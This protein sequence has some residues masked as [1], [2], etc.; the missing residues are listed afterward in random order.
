MGRWFLI[1]D[2]SRG[3]D[4]QDAPKDGERVLA[5]TPAAL[6]T[7]LRL[8]WPVIGIDRFSDDA[9]LNELAVRNFSDV[10]EAVNRL[11]T[12]WKAVRP[13][14]LVD[15][16]PFLATAFM[17]KLAADSYTF[18]LMELM[19]FA[20]IE[21]PQ[22]VRVQSGKSRFGPL[23]G[24]P[25]HTYNT[26]LVPEGGE[27]VVLPL[28]TSGA[29][30]NHVDVTHQ[31]FEPIPH[32]KQMKH[33]GAR[34]LLRA[35]NPNRYH[36]GKFMAS[37]R[38]AAHLRKKSKSIVVATGDP[39]VRRFAEFATREQGCRLDWWTN[40]DRRPVSSRVLLGATMSPG[41]RGSLPLDDL[42]A[43]TRT[44]QDSDLWR[45]DGSSVA[46]GV[47]VARIEWFVTERLS[48]LV[49]LYTRARSYFAAEKPVALLTGACSS[50]ASHT[51][52]QAAKA[53]G[54]PHIVF[55]HGGCYGYCT[56]PTVNRSDLRVASI[57]AA[58]G[59][60]VVADLRDQT[61][62]S[63]RPAIVNC[64]WPEGIPVRS[65][66][67][68]DALGSRDDPP[69][70]VVLYVTNG[71]NG[72]RRYGPYHSTNAIRIVDMEVDI[73]KV[74][75]EWC[76]ADLWVKLHYKEKLK[77]PVVVRTSQSSRTPT[78]FIRDGHF[79]NLLHAADVVI[80]DCP[81]TTLLQSFAAGK[82]VVLIDHEVHRYT[83]RGE[84]ALRDAVQWVSWPSP[85]WQD[86]LISAVEDALSNG[87]P[88]GAA[89][90]LELY[91]QPAYRPE[92][93]WNELER[94]SKVESRVE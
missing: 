34:R 72:D 83:R 33:G 46:C 68:I 29:L 94:F 43:A 70:S 79:A 80:I 74:L 45:V 20:E 32:R 40:W 63:S 25:L 26:S 91:G 82:P 24:A 44:L 64:G 19:T 5:L 35:I 50:D 17:M 30:G 71:L 15:Y 14:E 76:G 27:S 92:M 53:E 28:L 60:G 38:V 18:R 75:Q 51:L 52:S 93:L 69:R 39:S 87:P 9:S 56:L 65:T 66:R 31:G 55:Q 4:P 11:S 49:D 42:Q 59:D 12:V 73:V 3:L 61:P 78:R 37:R 81:S 16:D 21:K 7:C 8:G 62:D 88:P 22:S 77:N 36:L 23:T 13:R 6:N 2:D 57:F 85:S 58:W 41:W 47:L 86:R 90:F 1:E 48:Y 84:A 89:R 54:V 67:A 10:D